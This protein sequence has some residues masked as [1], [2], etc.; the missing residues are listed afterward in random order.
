LKSLSYGVGREEYKKIKTKPLNLHIELALSEYQEADARLL[1]VPPG[2]FV[3]ETLGICRVDPW[4]PSSIQCLKPFHAPGL[5]A[6]FDPQEFPC[7]GD[8]HSDTIQEDA[9]SHAWEF[10]NHY[11]FP[12]A[13]YTP[14]ADYSIW[15]RPVSLLTGLD[16]K[17]RQ[18]TKS[19][20]VCPGSE[21]RLARPELKRQ[22]RI[23]LDL[24]DVRLQDLVGS[25]WQ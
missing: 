7:T 17:S 24:P 25:D 4:Q 10:T 14:I 9:V 3:D 19:L 2:T 12:D 16:A 21:I 11:S 18:R 5:M 20:V 6:T 23:Q 15:F 1:P 22:V 13:N 8:E